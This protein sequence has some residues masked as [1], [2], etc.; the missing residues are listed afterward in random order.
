LY[1]F[2]ST[3]FPVFQV[4]YQHYT[5]L[6]V[7][8]ED[9]EPKRKP[10]GAELGMVLDSLVASRAIILEEGAAVRRKAENER[11]MLLNIEQGEVEKVLGDIGGKVWKNI[12]GN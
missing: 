6:P 8:A 4:V 11:R 12:L 2:N 3:D 7:L 5:Y 10:T 9:Y 1:L